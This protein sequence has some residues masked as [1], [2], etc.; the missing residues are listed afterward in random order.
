MGAFA[1]AI[2][3]GIL[4]DPNFGTLT[5]IFKSI[6]LKVAFFGNANS[7]YT[8][9]FIQIWIS[10]GYAMTIYFANIMSIPKDLY[11]A[12][13]IDGAGFFNKVRNIIIPMISPSITI[14]IMLSIIG[15]LKLFD[16]VYVSTQGGPFNSTENLPVMIYNQAFYLGDHGYGA[17]LNVI[18][19]FIIVGISI[20]VMQFRKRSKL[21]V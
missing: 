8:I 12:A 14:N 21:D 11:E 2:I 3:W 20:A 15:S 16:I 18:Q 1:V 10:L 4:M 9:I 13:E 17:A 19:F 5:T 7:I 6:G